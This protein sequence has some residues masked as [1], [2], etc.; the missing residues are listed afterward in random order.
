MEDEH[1]PENLSEDIILKARSIYCY[2]DGDDKLIDY[3]YIRSI[4]KKGDTPA[5]TVELRADV[6]A[7]TAKDIDKVSRKALPVPCVSTV[8]LSK[9]APFLAVRLHSK[10]RAGRHQAAQ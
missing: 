5:V 7:K 6:L 4:V 2:L 10:G 8:F 9:T 3:E 1:L